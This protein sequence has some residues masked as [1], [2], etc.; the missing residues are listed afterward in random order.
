QKLFDRLAK[1]HIDQSG[2]EGTIQEVD[3]IRRLFNLGNAEHILDVGCG[4]G[5]HSVELA[6]RGYCVTGLD[7]SRQMINSARWYARQQK[8]SVR[9]VH[10]DA[11]RMSFDREFDGAISICEG[12]FGLMINDEDNI[13]I[14]KPNGKLL[15]NVLHAAFAFRHPEQDVYFDPTTCYGY[16]TEELTTKTGNLKKIYCCNRYYTFPEIKKILE[17]IG[18]VVLRGYGCL[19]G[20]FRRKKIELDDFEILVYAVKPS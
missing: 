7:Y 17:E 5:R 14:L 1:E 12:A 20:Q 16:W 18:F 10:Q 6:K 11:R 4:T 8:V 15:L 9:F 13:L 3:F 2:E 19:T